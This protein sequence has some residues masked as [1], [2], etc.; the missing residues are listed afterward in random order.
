MTDTPTSPSNPERAESDPGRVRARYQTAK[1]LS[2]AGFGD[3]HVLSHEAADRALS[4]RTRRIIRALAAEEFSSQR[5]LAEYLDADPGNIK[6]D[7]AALIDEDIVAIE[8]DGQ[9][10][11]PYLK[12]DTIVVEPLVTDVTAVDDSETVVEA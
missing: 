1:A 7:L 2:S 3:V 4:Q 10:K 9:A 6:R 5:K 11:R 12:H 8:Q